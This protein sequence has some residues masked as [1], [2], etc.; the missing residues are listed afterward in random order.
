[1]TSWAF[2]I[3]VGCRASC[4]NMGV[5]VNPREWWSQKRKELETRRPG[6][7][8]MIPSV[9]ETPLDPKEK[10]SLDK[11]AQDKR[12]KASQCTEEGLKAGVKAASIAAVVSAIPTLIIARTVP[13][14]KAN[15]NYTGQALV[16]SAVTIASYFI[17]AEQTILECSRKASYAASVERKQAAARSEAA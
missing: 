12:S 6:C 15:L 1:V 3:F 7:D 5:V 14:A 17:V 8:F 9:V 11:I 16:I 2:R 10:Q 13:W 4:F